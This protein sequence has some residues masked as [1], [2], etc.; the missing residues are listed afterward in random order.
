MAIQQKL[1]TQTRSEAHSDAVAAAGHQAAADVDARA[2][3]SAESGDGREPAARGGPDRGA[4]AGR[5]AAGREGRRR[6]AGRE[7]TD[8]L[9]RRRLRVLLRRLPRRRLPVATAL[10][11]QGAAADREHA[12][13][14]RLAVRSPAVAADPADRATTRCARSAARS[15]ATST[16]TATWS[17]RSTRSRRWASGPVADVERALQHV[18]TFDPIGVGRARPA[19]VPAGCRFATSGSR[20]RRP[21]R[22]S[23][24]HLRLLQ[25][26]QVPEIAR[27]LGMSIEDLKRAHR[28]HPQPRS[29]AGQPLQPDA[30]RSTSSPTSTSSRSRTSTS[31]C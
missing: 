8:S 15:S 30:S 23:R 29:E 11:S 18:Q 19:G 2:G 24:E 22:S 14:H 17:P 25:N 27:K 3:G 5:A 7:K 16:T 21:R 6:K 13:D 26:H 4:A 1:H 12:L 10:R 20:A 31:R 28:D 9:G